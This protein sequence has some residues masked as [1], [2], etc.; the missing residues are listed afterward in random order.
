MVERMNRQLESAVGSGV[1]ATTTTSIDVVDEG[2]AFAVTADLPGFEKE[3]IDVR[4]DGNRLT[5]AAE[6][7]SEE[8]ATDENYVRRERRR[9]SVN[10]SVMLPD[11][12]VESEVSASYRNGVLTV[13]LPKETE[14]EGGGTEIEVE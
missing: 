6:R 2:D 8:E 4:L 3:D 1:P 13:R 12:V 7:D 11:D 9:Q 14:D 10:R 5:V